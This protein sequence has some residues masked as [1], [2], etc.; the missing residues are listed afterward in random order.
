VKFYV[1]VEL[2]GQGPISEKRF[3]MLADALYDLDGSDP[4]ISDADL[5][6]ALTEGRVT[7]TMTVDAADPVAAATKALCAVRSAIHAIGGFTPGW[8]EARSV[9]RVAPADASDRIFASA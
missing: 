6:A 3:T 4:G 2:N 9:L 8:E 5:G 1:E 7:A